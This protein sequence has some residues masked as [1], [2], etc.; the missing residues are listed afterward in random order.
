MPRNVFAQTSDNDSLLAR[1]SN[2]IR[3][4]IGP[5]G[6]RWLRPEGRLGS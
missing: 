1:V 4:R 5:Y 3:T 6:Y 2:L